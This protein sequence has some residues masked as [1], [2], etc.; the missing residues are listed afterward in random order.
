MDENAKRLLSSAYSLRIIHQ[1]A[2]KLRHAIRLKG[3][4]W[5][6]YFPNH[7]IYAFFAFNSLYNID[8]ELSYRMGRVCT[9]I[10]EN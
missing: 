7:F 9:A 8:W 2:A 4:E 10:D 5:Q 3:E 6:E 1:G